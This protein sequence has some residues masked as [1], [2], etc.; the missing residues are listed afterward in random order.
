M[1]DSAGPGPKKMINKKMSGTL[2]NA[3][4]IFAPDNGLTFFDDLG[5]RVVEAESLLEAAHRFHRPPMLM[6]LP[7]LLPNRSAA[8]PRPAVE[9]G[10]PP[11]PLKRSIWTQIHGQFSCW[12]TV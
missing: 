9:C 1:L 5:W 8:P 12:D 10:C 6:R 11:Y 3:P 2:Q 7:A 4:F